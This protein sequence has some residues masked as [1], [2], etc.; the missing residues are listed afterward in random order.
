MQSLSQLQQLCPPPPQPLDVLDVKAWNVRFRELGTRLPEQLVRMNAIYGSGFFRSVQ[1]PKNASF[2]VAA[3][4]VSRHAITRISELR[5]EKMRKPNAFPAVLYFEPGG[6]LPI[7][8]IGSDVDI[9]FCTKGSNPD[10][11]PV[12][13]LRVKSNQVHQLD[14]GLL[15]LLCSVVGGSFTSELFLKHI[16]NS[17][18][19]HFQ[20]FVETV[21]QWHAGGSSSPHV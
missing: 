20:T 3:S 6:L 10:K 17:R 21:Q 16:P 1:S 14:I 11:W 9:C 13:L 18:G 2:S 8:K 7:G 4:V 5:L 19:Y 15:D 12:A